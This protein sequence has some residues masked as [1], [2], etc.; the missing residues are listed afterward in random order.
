MYE[1]IFGQM[2]KQLGQVESWLDA[3]AAFANKKRVDPNL[4]LS[5]RL[6]PN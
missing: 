1:Q 3:V 4:F 5:F 6:A 2:R